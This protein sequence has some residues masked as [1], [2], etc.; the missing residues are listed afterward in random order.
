MLNHAIIPCRKF[1]Q[2][3][4]GVKQGRETDALIQYAFDSFSNFAT[5]PEWWDGLAQ[6]KKDTLSMTMLNWTEIP[7]LGNDSGT[8]IPSVDRFDDWEVERLNWLR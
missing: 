1:V 2:S 4:M 6:Q 5:E 8:L 3:L 7:F